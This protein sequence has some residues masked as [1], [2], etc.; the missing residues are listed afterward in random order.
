MT[1][2]HIARPCAETHCRIS[3]MTSALGLLPSMAIGMIAFGPSHFTEDEDF[4]D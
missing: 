3:P 1:G 4:A 2:R